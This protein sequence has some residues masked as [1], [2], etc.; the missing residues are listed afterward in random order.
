MDFPKFPKIFQN[1]PKFSKIFQEPI[2][3]MLDKIFQSQKMTLLFARARARIYSVV[4]GRSLAGRWPVAGR[5]L[6]GRWP[7]A[8]RSL[9]GRWPVAGLSL[10]GRWPVAGRSLAGRWR[11]L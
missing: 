3:A 4:A 7:V 8:G 1:F 10:A 2:F 11:D 9:A 6:A 5:S